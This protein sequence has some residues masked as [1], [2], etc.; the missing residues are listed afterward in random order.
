MAHVWAH[1]VTCCSQDRPLIW[2]LMYGLIHAASCNLHAG[3]ALQNPLHTP[4]LL[5]MCGTT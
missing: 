4:L 5:K 3:S 1:T 2:D